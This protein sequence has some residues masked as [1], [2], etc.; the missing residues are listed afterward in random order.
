LIRNTWNTAIV[1]EIAPEPGDITIEK[2][3]YSGFYET[4]LDAVL[5]DLGLTHLVFTGCTTSVCVEATLR[6]AMARDYHCLILEDCTAEPIGDGL[7]RTNHEA[8]LLAIETLMGWVT[9]SSSLITAIE[10]FVLGAT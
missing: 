10:T 9:T 1:D 2:H 6:D 4:E 3:R 7:P 8:S 5:E